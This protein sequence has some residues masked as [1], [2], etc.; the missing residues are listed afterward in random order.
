MSA[1]PEP[2]AAL[3]L[4]AT[5]IGN[6]GDITSRAV[7]ILRNVDRLYAEDTR[8]SRKLLAHLGIERPLIACHEHNEQALASEICQLLKAGTSCGFLSD[9]GTP[10][11]SDPGFRLV[12]Q[13]RREGLP[14][15]SIPGACALTAALSISGLPTDRFHFFG[16]LPP[17]KS[18]R[19]RTFEEQRR[20]ES[21]L[22]FYES[23]HRIEKFLID[24]EAIFGAE[25]IVSVARELT[26]HHETVLTGSLEEVR[27]ALSRGSTK[28]EFV[29]AI[30][31]EGYL[32]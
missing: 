2:E 10:A 9:A 8:H 11:I 27:A 14:V 26:K 4:I 25:R 22:V 18:A 7:A 12:R 16:F 24:A 21:T 31:K 6:L 17:K 28:G 32:L 20:S 5:P 23:T 30:A 15:V 1:S 13:C 29:I 3:H 19:L